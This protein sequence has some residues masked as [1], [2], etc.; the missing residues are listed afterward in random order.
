MA[1]SPFQAA[2]HFS[3]GFPKNQFADSGCGRFW[4]GGSFLYRIPYTGLSF[5]AGIDFLIY[6]SETRSVPFITCS[7]VNVDV[8]PDQQHFPGISH[9]ETSAVN[10]QNHSLRGWIVR[11]QLSE[12][13]YQC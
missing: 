8:T 7:E 3:L 9:D 6:G 13:E 12:Y 4:R 11:I 1:Q 5:G 10:L 2:A